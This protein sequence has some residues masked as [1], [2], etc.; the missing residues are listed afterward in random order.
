MLVC[1][2][3][4]NSSNQIYLVPKT[5]IPSQRNIVFSISYR[6]SVFRFS[7]HLVLNSN[8]HLHSRQNIFSSTTTGECRPMA[9][10]PVL[11]LCGLRWPGR[12]WW[13]YQTEKPGQT[14]LFPLI[15]HLLQS[16]RILHKSNSMITFS[17]S[18]T[19]R[20]TDLICWVLK[21]AMSL[22]TN[23]SKAILSDFCRIERNTAIRASQKKYSLKWIGQKSTDWSSDIRKKYKRNSRKIHASSEMG[24]AEVT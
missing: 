7:V 16:L 24:K 19:C 2:N 17:K 21:S 18:W 9:E 15:F 1:V 4:C 10:T 8:L 5:E 12:L 6:Y 11:T 22:Y 13:T 20:W 14:F 3:Y 23:S